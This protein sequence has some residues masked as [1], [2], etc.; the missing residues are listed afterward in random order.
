MLGEIDR[1][2]VHGCSDGDG[3]GDIEGKNETILSRKEMGKRRARDTIAWL[4]D[5][6]GGI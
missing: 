1:W 5:D 3:D 4:H 2:G 6:G